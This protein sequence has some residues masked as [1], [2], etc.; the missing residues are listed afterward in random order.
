M[1]E[2]SSRRPTGQL[3]IDVVHAAGKLFLERGFDGTS[4]RDI[5]SAAG[6][7]QSMLYRYFPNKSAL[8]ETAVLEPFYEF[9]E[10]FVN[11]LRQHTTSDLPNELLFA[12][13]NERLYDLTL[14]N[15]QMLVA[16]LAAQSYSSDAVGGLTDSL[17][18][19][20]SDVVQ[21]LKTDRAA[22]GWQDVDVEVVAR[23]VIAMVIGS[24]LLDPFLFGNGPERPS[25][26]R[27]LNE[28][29]LLELFG[30]TRPRQTEPGGTPE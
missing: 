3:R 10:E 15:R 16:L 5:A 26:R 21:Q 2:R 1:V 23:E 17:L 22:R 11:D 7:S 20:I 27:I 29:T 24:A 18:H 6:T 14:R 28:M 8:F 4:M 9:L 12:T 30:S 19:G 25:R 13:F